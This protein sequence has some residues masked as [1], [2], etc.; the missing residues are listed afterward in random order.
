MVSYLHQPLSDDVKPSYS[1]SFF[2]GVKLSILVSIFGS[3][4]FLC[5]HLGVLWISATLEG[6]GIVSESMFSDD[7]QG[8]LLLLFIGHWTIGFLLTFLISIIPVVFAGLGNTWLLIVLSRSTTL[9]SYQGAL[10]GMFVGGIFSMI[11]IFLGEMLVFY[12][13]FD[14]PSRVMIEIMM[15]GVLVALI[16][17]AWH[18]RRMTHFLNQFEES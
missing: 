11:P 13:M 1:S 9:K 14:A 7:R 8:Y 4:L 17:G 16:V 2:E 3:F 18:G 6:V 5:V 10:V 15:S 12:L